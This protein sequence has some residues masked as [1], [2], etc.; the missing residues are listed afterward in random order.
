MRF[1]L[2]GATR[3]S[4]DAFEFG[5]ALI[6]C[7]LN[8]K[9]PFVADGNRYYV[10]VGV[11]RSASI[12]V[13]AEDQNSNKVGV[14]VGMLRSAVSAE[15]KLGIEQGRDREL[16]YKGKVPLAFGV[17]LAEMKY[18]KAQEKFLLAAVPDA[19]SIRAPRYVERI[20]IGD[21]VEGSAFIDVS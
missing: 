1:K 13:S 21:P 11:V 16:T 7:Q 6:P 15:G 5:K 20:F 9:Q 18:D 12:T 17:E 3:D 8:A 2:T 14:D 4:V 19:Q 10:A